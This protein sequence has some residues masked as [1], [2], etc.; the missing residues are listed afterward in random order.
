MVCRLENRTE[1]RATLQP[2]LGLAVPATCT[3]ACDGVM[4]GKVQGQSPSPPLWPSWKAKQGGRPDNYRE[5]GHVQME[6]SKGQCQDPGH[7]RAALDLLAQVSHPT[8][9]LHA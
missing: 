7:A 9:V 6:V 5:R 4:V 8:T 3:D 1:A 2:V